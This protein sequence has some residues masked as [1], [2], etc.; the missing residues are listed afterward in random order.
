MASA[1]LRS[2]LVLQP[3]TARMAQAWPR[4]KAIFSSRQA[5]ASQ[6]QQCMHSQATSSP[7]RKGATARR[8]GSGA[9]GML[10]AKTILPSR[11]R[12]TRNRALAW[13]STPASNRM[14]AGGVKVR[15]VKASCRFVGAATCRAHVLAK[16]SLHEYPAAEADRGRQVDFARREALAGGPGQPQPL[17]IPLH[18]LGGQHWPKVPWQRN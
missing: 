17:V 15:M 14:P 18:H 12:M 1:S 10:R 13:R 7:S 8:N 2:H 16:E 4:T 3:C 9:A 6:Y 5:S 11:S